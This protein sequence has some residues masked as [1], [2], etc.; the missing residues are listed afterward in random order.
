LRSTV[1]FASCCKTWPTP[2]DDHVGRLVIDH[3]I[4]THAHTSSICLASVKMPLG[5]TAFTL[6]CTLDDAL[7]VVQ[8]V[9]FVS[10]TGLHI[11]T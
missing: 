7:T 3:I 6:Q 8:Q 5:T 11:L 10:L 1:I 2:L 4:K 9:W